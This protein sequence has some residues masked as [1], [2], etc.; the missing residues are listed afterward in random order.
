MGPSLAEIFSSQP[1]VIAWKETHGRSSFSGRPWEE[2]EKFEWEKR[3]G[4]AAQERERETHECEVRGAG[5]WG[6]D[7]R[8]WSLFPSLSLKYLASKLSICPI[9][10]LPNYN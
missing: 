6:A 3:R 7:L 1:V 9:K 5:V 8:G 10:L 2:R 4:V